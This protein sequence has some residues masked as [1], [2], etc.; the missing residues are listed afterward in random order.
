[1]RCPHC[2]QETE[3]DFDDVEIAM[4]GVAWRRITCQGCGYMFDEVYTFRGF[5]DAFTGE[6]I[7]FTIPADEKGLY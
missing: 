4:D 1:M 6:L 7:D 5:E 3:F 2:K